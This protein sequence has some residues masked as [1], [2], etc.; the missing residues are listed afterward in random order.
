MAGDL[1]RVGVGHVANR[2]VRQELKPG[3]SDHDA[4]DFQFFLGEVRGWATMSGGGPIFT[5]SVF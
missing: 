1:R 2:R 4:A 3:D 5:V